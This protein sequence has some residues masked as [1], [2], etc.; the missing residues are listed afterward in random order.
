MEGPSAAVCTF[1][2]AYVESIDYLRVL[3]LLARQPERT[4]TADETARKAAITP[5][6]ALA[7]LQRMVAVGLATASDA[8]EFR[9]APRA[10]EF[11]EM[12]RE[13]IDLDDRKPVTLIRLVY[14]RK[15]VSA[16][17]FADA[18]RLRRT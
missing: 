7:L 18:F 2:N 14:G 8:A 13:L 3:L 15:S 17:A 1:I 10:V 12:V 6:L 16:Q 9:Y 4:W 5:A 11:E